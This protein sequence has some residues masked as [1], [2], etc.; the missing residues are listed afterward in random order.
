MECETWNVKQKKEC[1]KIIHELKNFN[2]GISLSGLSRKTDFNLFKLKKNLD[3][4]ESK[5][6][7]KKT[8]IGGIVL[9]KLIK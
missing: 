9:I 8:K 1:N 4:L 2:E 5:N 3:I 6:I 7:I